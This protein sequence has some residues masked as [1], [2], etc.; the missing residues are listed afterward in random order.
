MS[1]LLEQRARELQQRKRWGWLRCLN[2]ARRQLDDEGVIYDAALSLE[3]QRQQVKI[4]C[5][6]CGGLIVLEVGD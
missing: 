2:E 3:P 4:K 6:H 1:E 5:P